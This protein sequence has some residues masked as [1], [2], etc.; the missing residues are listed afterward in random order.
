MAFGSA[1]RPVGDG[2]SV[3]TD[4]SVTAC[5]IPLSMRGSLQPPSRWTLVC[6]TFE[7]C[8][9]T[10]SWHCTRLPDL[11]NVQPRIQLYRYLVIL[12]LLHDNMV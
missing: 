5:P 1:V 7:R 8:K 9:K 11:S 2:G 12:K 6:L 10:P 4:C 3:W